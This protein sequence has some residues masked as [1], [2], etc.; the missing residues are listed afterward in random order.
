MITPDDKVR[1]D[2][3]YLLP[4][5]GFQKLLKGDPLIIGGGVAFSDSAFDG[6]E[7]VVCEL[8][9]G[10]YDQSINADQNDEKG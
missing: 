5:E 4:F 10:P 6:T 9:V 8:S 2:K 3:A 1:S 7:I